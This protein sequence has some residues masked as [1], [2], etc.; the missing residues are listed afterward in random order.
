MNAD[1]EGVGRILGGLFSGQ[2]LICG[3]SRALLDF[4]KAQASKEASY[5]ELRGEG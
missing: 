2:T 3:K 1:T 4:K 5:P